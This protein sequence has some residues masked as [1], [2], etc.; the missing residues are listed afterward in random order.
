MRIEFVPDD[1]LRAAEVSK[2]LVQFL[3]TVKPA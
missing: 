1:E 2:Q 3:R